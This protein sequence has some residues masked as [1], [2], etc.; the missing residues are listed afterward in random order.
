MKTPFDKIYVISL[1]TNKSRQESIKNQMEELG[2][3]YEFVY[4]IDFI[5][6][7]KDGVY[8]TIKWP[9][10]F[11]MRFKDFGIK[12]KIAEYGVAMTH[13]RAVLQAYEFGYKNV[14]ILEDDICFNK[15]KDFVEYYLNHIPNDADFVTYDP[16]ICVVP[17]NF[18]QTEFDRL[19]RDLWECENDYMDL[20]NYYELCG[21][22]AYG[23][24]NRKT[25]KLYLDSQRNSLMCVDHVIGL[26]RNPSP[27]I[28]RYCCSKC[29]CIDQYNH[30]CNFTGIHNMAFENHYK[31][32]FPQLDKSMFYGPKEYI[33]SNV[34]PASEIKI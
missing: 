18:D 12:T 31:K 9:Y 4:G 30:K 3:N 15:D 8:Q 10:L 23:L 33:I 7:T 6:F 34:V 27:L 13:Y 22:M 21:A 11:D 19:S 17:P 1:I 16:R 25:M 20:E 14:L 28:K 24:M 2:L 29:I 5:N 32:M 26:F